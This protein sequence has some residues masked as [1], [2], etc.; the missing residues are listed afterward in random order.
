MPTN[1]ALVHSLQIFG[2][3]LFHFFPDVKFAL[4][5]NE[6]RLLLRI[7]ERTPMRQYPRKTICA[8]KLPARAG[9]KLRP[10][11]FTHYKAPQ[12]P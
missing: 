9:V 12:N 1:L 5:F 4:I 2:L 3:Q 11:I 7:S 6:V 10:V 8:D